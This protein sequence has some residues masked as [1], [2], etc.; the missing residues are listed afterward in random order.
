MDEMEQ[1]MIDP[2]DKENR[3]PV[4]VYRI[5]RQIEDLITSSDGEP[6]EQTHGPESKLGRKRQFL[7]AMLLRKE[8]KHLPEA[9]FA[10][11][12]RTAVYEADPSLNRD[13]I[14]PALRA[15]GYQRV[16]EALLTY[17]EQ[18]TPREKAGAAQACYW[19]WLPIILDFRTGYE[20]FRRLCDENLRVR[21]DI[22][23][24][25]TFVENGDLDVRRSVISRLSLKPSDYPE[26]YRPLIPT[27]LHLA[28]THPDESIRRMVE[29]RLRNQGLDT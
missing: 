11:L 25:K 13:F 20:E 9:Y 1:T 10:P 22:L 8:W 15:F 7:R 6:S 14:E 12:T 21:R 5:L 19:A 2:N 29:L 27:A 24:L 18:G 26:A 23:L 16:Q 28:R 3:P 17:L 4:V